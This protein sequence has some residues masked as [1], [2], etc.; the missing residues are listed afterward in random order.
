MPSSLQLIIYK[1]PVTIGPFVGHC[2]AETCN[3]FALFYP[4]KICRWL[5]D[6]YFLK[7][8]AN[9]LATKPVRLNF[10]V[11]FDNIK[12]IGLSSFR[13]HVSHSE[14]TQN[15]TLEGWGV[16]VRSILEKGA[17]K[18]PHFKDLVT[19]IL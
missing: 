2:D 14:M 7:S 6:F 12:K 4:H 17:K 10:A 19:L 16:G 8:L 9:P 18:V 13:E 11:F 5:K 1:C 3:L 15:G